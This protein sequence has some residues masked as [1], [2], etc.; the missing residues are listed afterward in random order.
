MTR[1]V[2][3]AKLGWD[4]SEAK[5]WNTIIS[6]TAIIGL[7]IGSLTGGSLLQL[8]RR[9]TVLISMLICIVSAIIPMYV[10]EYSMAVGR[11]LVGLGAGIFNVA[12]GKLINETIPSSV[13]ATFAMAH[14]AGICFGFMLIFF[15]GAVLPDFDD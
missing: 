10:N 7:M 2:L 5:M 1:S 15:L 11:L 6:S 9:K 3:K 12:F 14:N 8:G 4:E 13:M